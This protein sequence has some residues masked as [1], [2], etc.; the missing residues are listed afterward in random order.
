MS[1]GYV[2][3]M[4]LGGR[5]AVV[6]GGAGLLGAEIAKCLCAHGADVLVLDVAAERGAAVAVEAAGLGGSCRFHRCDLS[7]VPAIPGIVAELEN[8]FGALHMWVNCAYPRTG[9]WGAKLEEVTP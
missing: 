7:D 3:M 6:S 2:S 1:D 9:D 5:L 8:R 4:N